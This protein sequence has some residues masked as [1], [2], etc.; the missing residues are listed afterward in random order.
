MGM[1]GGAMRDFRDSWIAR[2]LS[3]T[4]ILTLFLEM[5]APAVWARPFWEDKPP[6]PLARPR[7]SHSSRESH[8]QSVISKS[9][10]KIGQ[11]PPGAD[12]KYFPGSTSHDDVEKAATNSS[13]K[14]DQPSPTT[15]EAS[16]STPPPG[17]VAVSPAADDK[18]DES[19]EEHH[20][21]PDAE[22]DDSDNHARPELAVLLADPREN[23]PHEEVARQAF[24]GG[25]PS[26]PQFVNGA[27]EI[28]VNDYATHFHQRYDTLANEETI[29]WVFQSPNPSN[30]AIHFPSG[31][32]AAGL[33]WK[34]RDEGTSPGDFKAKYCLQVKVWSQQ[35]PHGKVLIE[36][37]EST[38]LCFLQPHAAI[39][40]RDLGLWNV[41][42]FRNGTEVKNIPFCAQYPTAAEGDG[43]SR[44]FD[45]RFGALDQ[46]AAYTSDSW[47]HYQKTYTPPAPNSHGVQKM[48]V[49]W[50]FRSP[51]TSQNRTQLQSYFSFKREYR[52]DGANST[53]TDRVYDALYPHGHTYK[54]SR[55]SGRLAH[56]TLG[57]GPA[58]PDYGSWKLCERVDQHGLPV[59]N[60]PVRKIIAV[61]QLPAGNIQQNKGNISY[62]VKVATFPESWNPG[63]LDW[64]LKLRNGADNTILASYEGLF[65]EE[66]GKQVR[67]AI[68]SWDG[69]D[70]VTGQKPAP[71]TMVIPELE[72]SLLSADAPQLQNLQR[73]AAFR[74]GQKSISVNAAAASG[75]ETYILAGEVGEPISVDDD[76]Y[77][78]LDDD[79][80]PI[81]KDDDGI[82]SF[83]IPNF[84]ARRG[85]RLRIVAIDTFGLCRHISGPIYLY[86]PASGQ[87]QLLRR[88]LFDD[89]CGPW[90]AGFVF[91]DLFYP[92]VIPSTQVTPIPVARAVLPADCFPHLTQEEREFIN[93][94]SIPPYYTID[95]T[96]RPIDTRP[97]SG[98]RAVSQIDTNNDQRGRDPY[99]FPF[100]KFCSPIPLNVDPSNGHYF[101]RF[102][103]LSVPTRGLPLNVG[104]NYV[105]EFEQVGPNF[106]WRWDFEERLLL[107]PGASQAIL[108]GADG[109][110]STFIRRGPEGEFDPLYRQEQTER[111]RQIDDRHYEVLFKDKTT[112]VFEIPSGG[113]VSDVEAQQAVL[114]K[115][116]DRNGNTQ[117]YYWTSDG[118][119][120]NKIQGPAPEQFLKFEWTSGDSPRL[121]QVIDHTGRC[122]RY[123]YSKVAHPQS[124]TG[125][126]WLLTKIVQPGET[127]YQ[128]S[129]HPI[130]GEH[131]YRLLDTRFNGVLQEKIGACD[132]QSG[133]LEEV[134]HYGSM[135]KYERFTDAD[136]LRRTRVTKSGS[137]GTPEGRSQV[138]E[139]VLDEFGRVVTQ[140]DPAGQTRQYGYNIRNDIT[141]M[142]DE[143]GHLR[144]MTFDE[145]H[146]L[147]LVDD[148][149]RRTQYTYNEKDELIETSNALSEVTRLGYDEH[150][151]LVQVT[152]NIGHTSRATYNDFGLLTSITNNAGVSWNFAYNSLGFLVEKIVPATSDG[153]SAASWK[154]TVDSLGR[155]TRQQDPLGRVYTA[156]Y[157][158]RDRLVQST[159]PGVTGHY[160]QE[161]Q[162]QQVLSNVYDRNDLLVSSTS[163]DGL[164]TRFSY[165]DC[166]QLTAV[167]EPGYPQPTRLKYDSFENCVKMTNPANHV[168]SYR[169]DVL[170][171]NVGLTYPNGD[172]ET[173]SYD[174]TSNLVAWNRGGQV[175]TYFYDE[176]SRLLQLECSATGD[177]LNWQYDD[178]DR[179]EGMQDS[180]GG[181][182]TYGYT[183]NDQLESIFRSDGKG[184]TY[185]YD[186]NDR[187]QSIE[188]NES[189]TTAYQYNERN[190]VVSATHAGHTV[191]YGY[192]IVGRR[193]RTDLPNGIQCRKSFDERN[194]LIYM[195]YQKGANPVLTYK[196]GHNQLGQRIVEEKNSA[197][198][199]KL[200]HYCY[201][202]RRELISSD[203]RIGNQHKVTNYRY[204]LNHNRVAQNQYT[205]QHNS[206]D[207]LTSFP[208]PG[209]SK[210]LAY[211][212]QGQAESAGDLNFTYNQSQQIKTAN[213]GQTNAEYIYDGSGRRVGKTV[214]GIRTD[215]LLLGQEVLKTYED[216]ILKADYFL[217]LNREGIC[218]DGS[219]KYYLSDGLGSTVALT[220]ETGNT[221]ASYDYSDYGETTQISGSADIYNPFLYTGQE[222]DS[223]L[224][225]Y[226]LRARHYSPEFGRFIA[227]DP[228]GYAGGS[229][230]YSYCAGDPLNYMDPTGTAIVNLYSGKQVLRDVVPLSTESRSSSITATFNVSL[231]WD[232]SLGLVKLKISE[233]VNLGVSDLIITGVVGILPTGLN[234][235]SVKSKMAAGG[236]VFSD[237]PGATSAV[238]SPGRPREFVWKVGSAC[239]TISFVLELIAQHQTLIKRG[240]G[241]EIIIREF[242]PVRINAIGRAN[243]NGVL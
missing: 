82:S 80:V 29:L 65:L 191:G 150:S 103:D 183:N 106:G 102:V 175:T 1:G 34:Y 41:H 176:R 79:R 188:D 59:R 54:V 226:N 70:E 120:L 81:W 23:M 134:A 99:P 114:Q 184:I 159:V 36:R 228:I 192:D 93:R 67:T 11:L 132:D 20:Q 100:I 90:P 85:Q 233:L 194:R 234:S 61:V 136:H 10:P 62:Q 122:V 69:L 170:N 110:E 124:P 135:L 187:L 229:N 88:S 73:S 91:L 72:V 71:G 205:Y 104:R 7:S 40:A 47:L 182:T 222:W 4:L 221:V 5:L 166:Q 177:T 87:R 158:E 9:S 137:E 28:F 33:E 189:E 127:T 195:N 145:R 232:T 45:E 117:S 168:T 225:M 115:K 49:E 94:N 126:D 227:R 95:S 131:Y 231:T 129:Y 140:I 37:K 147:V 16:Q 201:N 239:T 138:T 38:K 44:R 130:L 125:Y 213:G 98:I 157:D 152:D 230:Q 236:Q 92:I 173:F 214:N 181:E 109:T 22:A 63:D 76:L 64:K 17:S 172:E 112:H 196:Y 119:K 153:Q 68:Q 218:T 118:N 133:T 190:Q 58:L 21:H 185:H 66:P 208:G 224:G 57:G 121:K 15:T 111:L 101:H 165:D 144:E 193:V 53:L 48:S 55:S 202:P 212:G 240:L 30:N 223:E 50:S 220:D 180:S 209:S 75:A 77:L 241:D 89:G 26:K 216:G 113:A 2:R 19:A 167:Q 198:Q 141:S 143:L 39:A 204:D 116:V 207:Q 155:T 148:V 97:N 31:N 200:T 32:G 160:R 24:S 83:V 18:V 52:S 139:S 142:I 178:L 154:Y 219:W 163:L 210:A 3:L 162:H 242:F 43:L 35:W 42:M 74:S 156:C 13:A 96:C 179:V 107:L 8:V 211:N 123:E 56:F 203:R 199:C 149:G 238:G 25:A 51:N 186:L 169:F 27:H 86:H 164:Q 171:R 151:N 237:T 60:I 46:G 215:Y 78:Y 105:S 161:S 217:G 197:Q 6:Y 14:G 12:P 243:E 108:K 84:P 146:N 128:H 206:A 235:A 174:P